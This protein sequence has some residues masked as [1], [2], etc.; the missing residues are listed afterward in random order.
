[1]K[2]RNLLSKLISSACVTLSLFAVACADDASSSED[3]IGAPSACEGDSCAESSPEPQRSSGPSTCVAPVG[4]TCAHDS[5]G[6]GC[7][8]PANC[9][10]AC[11]GLRQLC[12]DLTIHGDGTIEGDPECVLSALRDGT[13]GMLRWHIAPAFNISYNQTIFI[14]GGR[15]VLRQVLEF[16]DISGDAD[17][18]GPSPLRDAAFFESCLTQT[19]PAALKACLTNAAVGCG[20]SSPN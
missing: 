18:D 5:F 15:R 9:T 7:S 14:M 20:L 12:D 8:S 2:P 17:R 13:E 19:S 1:M 10:W 6:D 4:A 11:T 3:K 16:N